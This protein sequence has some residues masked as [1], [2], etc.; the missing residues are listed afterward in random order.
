LRRMTDELTIGFIGF[1]EAGFNIARG[2]RGAGAGQIFAYDI[3]TDTPSL[4]EKIRQRAET[5]E[6]MLLDSSEALTKASNI[7]LSTVTAN[8]A[9]VAAEQTVPFLEPRHIYADLNSVSPSL[10]R[11]IASRIDSTGARFV[12]AAIMA[13]VP[14]H[15][16]LVP[17]LIGGPHAQAFVDFMAPYGMRLEI[18]SDTVGAAA[19]VKMCRSII[20]KGLEALVFECV[21]GADKYGATERVFAS[22]DESFP[23]IGPGFGSAFRWS[24]LAD[25]MVGRVVEHGARRAR[26]MEEVAE[27]LR[28]ACVEPIM[29][30]AAARRQDWAA[31]LNLLGHFGGEAPA[32]YRDMLRALSEVAKEDCH[33]PK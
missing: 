7:L 33:V 32:T 10:K 28:E 21:L 5:S 6:T 13:A 24:R 2:L 19:A 8:A 25:Y 4:G 20:V 26:E 14:P 27:A 29:A 18:I 11:S 9:A 17:M 15:G 22:L 16:H 23:G 3:N 12:E 31:R 1:G 30:E